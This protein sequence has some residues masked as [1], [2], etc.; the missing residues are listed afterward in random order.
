MSHQSVIVK[1]AS[2]E[3][4]VLFRGGK[5]QKGSEFVP[6]FFY[7][8]ARLNRLHGESKSGN[9]WATSAV[10]HLEIETEKLNQNCAKIS[11]IVDNAISEKAKEGMLVK[12]A[13]AP[14][15]RIF[16]TEINYLNSTSTKFVEMLTNADK[17]FMRL[18]TALNTG[19]LPRETTTNLFGQIN[20]EVRRLYDQTIFFE[21]HIQF[22]LTNHDAKI[23]SARSQ[24]TISKVGLPGEQVISGEIK[25]AGSA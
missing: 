15:K 21:K 13:Q 2:R 6:S 4:Q 23:Q 5:T 25:A 22:G 20:R 24:S 16:S 3:A 10:I 9:P 8:Y 17:T 19:L 18:V 12:I 11:S 7:C 1:L 14:D